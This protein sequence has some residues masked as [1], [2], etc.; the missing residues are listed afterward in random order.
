MPAIS[1]RHGSSSFQ[2]P[3]CMEKVA[4]EGNDKK[5]NILSMKRGF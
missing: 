3:L 4:E 5:L 1:W 2:L